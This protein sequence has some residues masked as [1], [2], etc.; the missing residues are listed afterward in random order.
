MHLELEQWRAGVTVAPAARATIPDAMLSQLLADHAAGTL[1]AAAG[2][3]GPAVAAASPPDSAPPV[4]APS[5][6]ATPTVARA[7]ASGE[8][9]RSP[10]SSSMGSPGDGDGDGDGDAMRDGSGVDRIDDAI[11]QP[12]QEAL[13]ALVMT[14]PAGATKNWW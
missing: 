5:L 3:A 13:D 6:P 2:G 1:G 8:G 9:L 14:P 10:P 11:E 4:A 7:T 12:V